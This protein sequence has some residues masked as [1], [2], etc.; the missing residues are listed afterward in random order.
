MKHPKEN[1]TITM[2]KI[3]IHES[4][5]KKEK[6]HQVFVHLILRR[7]KDGRPGAELK[8]GI[9]SRGERICSRYGGIRRK[10]EINSTGGDKSTKPEPLKQPK[11]RRRLE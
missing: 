10:I 8:G 9:R 11:D 3:L 6:I 1:I 2:R 5:F 7:R 4:R